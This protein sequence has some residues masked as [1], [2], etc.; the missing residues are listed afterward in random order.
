MNST[1]KSQLQ[2]QSELKDEQFYKELQFV[3]HWYNKFKEAMV[4]KAP[5]TRAWQDYLDAYS[6]DYFK[7]EAR[8]EYKSNHISNFIMSTIESIR[9]ILIDNNPRFIAIA[10]TAEG[11]EK[12][13]KVQM[14]LD[15]EF[16][17]EKMSSKIPRQ[18]L[19]TLIIGS[20]VYFVPWDTNVKSEY[21]GEIRAIEVNPFNLFPDPLATSVEDA[22]YIIYASY[23][24]VNILKK[25]F[26]KK[27][28]KLN[29]GEINYPELVG[30]R[31]SDM[32]KVNNQ[33]LVLE[34]W[35]R[36]YTSVE[37]EE[38]G[39]DGKVY[40]VRKRKYPKGRVLTIAPEL[41]IL[42]D[43]KENPY[44][45]GNFPF[46][47]IK[48]YDIPFQFW[49]EGEVKH[50]LSPQKYLNDLS[51]QV[52]DNARLTVNMPWIIDKNAGIGYGQL[53]NRPGLVIRKN[54]GTTVERH[55]PPSLPQYVSEKIEE[56]KRDIETISG[57]H[58]VTQG[59]RPVGIQAGNAIMALQEAGQT[60]IRL[61][62]KMLELGLSDLANMW[63]KRMQQFWKF[64]RWVHYTDDNS[65]T[66]YEII[67]EEDL[68]H[69]FDIK[70][71]AGSTM[72]KNKSA[73]LDIMIRLGQTTAEDGLPVV[74]RE[75]ILDFIDVPHKDK[76]IER[77]AEL[78]QQKN[79]NEEVG[80]QVQALGQ[81]MQQQVQEISG[82]LKD[83]TNVVQGMQK[84]IEKLYSFHEKEQGEK[85]REEEKEKMRTEILN[86]MQSDNTQSDTQLSDVVPTEEVG[87]TTED[88]MNI[89]L[90][91]ELIE[92]IS[93]LS[94]EE[95]Q[96][97]ISVRPELQ[98]IIA[99]NLQV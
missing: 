16:D 5:F 38:T 48:D 39:E 91:D 37:Y 53:T 74:D 12:S 27:A 46:V 13:R 25:L 49:G 95:L 65:K 63:Y 69:D 35:C 24:H 9:P 32:G 87:Q 79:I 51:N 4:H 21:D 50:L 85:K 94:D 62:V 3:N 44:D 93:S 64:E 57:V 8:P 82:I 84:D 45:D 76:I 83:V 73:M 61:K 15:Y 56:L 19:M 28:D 6:G 88:N 98:Q 11:L 23:K 60:R 30:N 22:E 10:R 77:F 70:I 67:T 29:G 31:G 96:E 43:D 89:E 1:E 72:P 86:E 80:Q 41:G 34:I 71:S 40:K 78:A 90:T 52:I 81:Q 26:P 97:L 59:R 99:N 92:M 20:A 36:D 14:A 33:V 42:L 47:I 54:P 2:K 58:D 68:Q 75:T 66:Q 55:S 7:R 17:R 18:A